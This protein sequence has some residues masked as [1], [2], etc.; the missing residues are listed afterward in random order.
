[1]DLNINIITNDKCQVIIQDLKEGYLAENS[2]VIVKGKFKYSETASIS[3]LQHNKSTGP[4]IQNPV[5]TDHSVN[6]PI[7][8]PVKFDGWFTV[9]YIVLPTREWFESATEAMLQLYETIYFIDGETIY[10]YTYGQDEPYPV[11]LEVVVLRNIEDTTI[12]KVCENYVSIC[13]LNKCYID[14]CQQIFRAAGFS[15]CD[16]KHDIDSDLIYR[17]DLVWMAINVVK[18]M[19]E[20][21]QLA[22]AERIIERI[23]GC[24][25]LCKN[26]FRQFTEHDCGCGGR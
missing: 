3:V 5:Y 14:L 1:M 4:I 2:S 18:Y 22:E 25:G 6:N 10:G 15:P 26:E 17:R 19:V 20:L 9:N 8:L 24:N 21:N 11:D 7:T 23:G 12:S 16:K 13:F